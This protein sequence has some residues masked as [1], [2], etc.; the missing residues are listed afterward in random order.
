MK[1]RILEASNTQYLPFQDQ[2]H[3]QRKDIEAPRK[4]SFSLSMISYIV[5]EMAFELLDTS[6]SPLA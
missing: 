4:F 2:A 1:V 6:Y 5:T 3:C